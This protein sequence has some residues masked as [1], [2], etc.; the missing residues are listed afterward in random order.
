MT[1]EPARKLGAFAPEGEPTFESEPCEDAMDHA[2]VGL[3]VREIVA[4]IAF[5]RPDTALEII[6]GE[7][8]LDD[9]FDLNQTAKRTPWNSIYV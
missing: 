1:S 3:T 8:P 2:V 6:R 5:I 9:V 4:E 7:R